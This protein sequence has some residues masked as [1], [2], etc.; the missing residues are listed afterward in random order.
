M[1]GPTVRRSAT[2]LTA[3]PPG[4]AGLHPA[5][6]GMWVFLAVVAMLF[7]A[8]LSAYIIRRE[9]ADWVMIRLPAI[10][11]ANTALLAVSSLTLERGRSLARRG[12]LAAG[13]SWLGGTT[14]L[15][16]A[17]VGGQLLAWWQLAAQGVFL[18]T[19]PHGSFF[20]ILTGLHALHL[21]G[22]LILLL[23]AT[24]SRRTD[25]TALRRV[26]LATTYWH[27]LGALWIFLF[28]VLATV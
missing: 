16:L 15:G 7:A 9:S 23:V 22:G 4:S 27:F 26:D 13:R 8:F 21:L 17:F 11:W 20:Y 19:S 12:G 3:P 2:T 5:Q 6:L 28:V 10:L 14:F 24:L 1:H 25:A 18:P